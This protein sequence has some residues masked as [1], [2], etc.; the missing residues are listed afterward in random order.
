MLKIA[1]CDDDSALL[2]VL[3]KY[4][5]KLGDSSLD[6]DIYFCADELYKYINSQKIRYDV[7]ILDIEMKEIGRAHV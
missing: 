3:E 2:E 5:D 1:L 7:Y 4:F 6:Y